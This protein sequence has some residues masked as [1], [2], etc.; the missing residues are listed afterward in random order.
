MSVGPVLATWPAVDETDRAGQF[1]DV[2]HRPRRQ[3]VAARFTRSV[4]VVHR[5]PEQ[6]TS[7]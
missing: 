2:V 5:R 6:A 1:V 7:D 3:V 4:P